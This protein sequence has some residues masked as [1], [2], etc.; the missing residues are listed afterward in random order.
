[1][2]NKSVWSQRVKI[3]PTKLLWSLNIIH[4]YYSIWH[5]TAALTLQFEEH[6][7]AHAGLAIRPHLLCH[8]FMDT[9][10]HA[11]HNSA[12]MLSLSHLQ[13]FHSHLRIYAQFE[14]MLLCTIQPSLPRWGSGSDRSQPSWPR[15]E[16]SRWASMHPHTSPF[17]LPQTQLD[18]SV[19]GTQ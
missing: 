7:Q 19:T 4:F 8:D 16:K 2:S 6:R 10:Q 3:C 11:V 13:S 5:I 12:C 17:A 1:M 14:R 15:W 9:L 18:P